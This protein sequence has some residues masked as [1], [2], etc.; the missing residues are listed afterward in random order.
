MVEEIEFIINKCP[1]G[2]IIFNRKMD[3]I[4]R[5]KKASM[6]L[7]RFELPEETITVTKRLFDAAER[8]K[9][10][11]LFP[12]EIHIT[13]K[14]DG[15]TSNWVFRLYIQ[16]KLN[17]L[18][19]LLIFEETVSNKL[20]MNGIRQ[21][22]KLTRRET[23]ILR[24]VIDGFKNTEI[25]L[26]LGIAEQTVKDHLSNVYLKTATEDRMALMRTLVYFPNNQSDL[27]L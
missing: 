7:N 15:S 14:L 16:E 22:Y 1:V 18:V 12:G 17:P 6:F 20:D 3:I 25:A 19:Y 23:D 9:L 21:Q 10:S 27:S 13:K 2:L 24:R 5:N 4:D 8:G 11:E 26:E